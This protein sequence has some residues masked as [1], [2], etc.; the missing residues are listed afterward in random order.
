MIEGH[1]HPDFW[2]VARTLEQQLQRAPLAGGAAVAVFHRGQRV[3]DIRGGNRDE[4][5]NEWTTQTMS[6]SFSTTKGVISTLL[7][8]LVD[9]GGI[10][11]EDR[12][13]KFWPEFAQHGKGE[14]TLRHLL[15][16]QAGLY[17]IRHLV[18]SAE[19]MLDWEY[20][21][22]ALAAAVAAHRPGAMSAY[23]GLTYGWLIGEVIQ[24][25][26]GR[27]VSELVR[28]E[29]AEPLGLDGFYIGVPDEQI[30]NV[31]RLVLPSE[32]LA[33]I[34]KLEKPMKRLQQALSFV[35]LPLDA[36]RMAAALA[37]AGIEHFDWS[38]PATLRACI[39]AANGTF[40]ARALAKMYAVL[41]A[42]GELDGVRLLSS[43]TLRRA[44]EIQTRKIDRVVPFPM[45]WRLGY[46][47]A[48]TTRG[49]PTRGFGHYGF[50]GSG[51]WADPEQQLS[52][53]LVLNSGLGTPFGDIRTAQIGGAALYC[54]R[55][56]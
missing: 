45:H 51:A 1:I 29:I 12:V 17:D 56:R 39:P 52:V 37:P 31:A 50:G 44:T 3:V 9:Q 6:V 19:R 18:D 30:K 28:S 11:Y 48:A 34:R 38:A 36:G 25:V 13:A 40:T 14:I 7:H 32:R 47:R 22:S 23:H 20:M 54:A 8:R 4:L 55:R 41:A 26:S 5:G 16:H 46:H 21:T 42:G 35:R 33:R 24:R 27:T 2:P 43:E 53:A 15:C 49:N 10:D